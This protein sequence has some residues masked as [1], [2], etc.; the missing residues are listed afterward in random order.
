M[1]PIIGLA[2]VLILAAACTEQSD[3]PQFDPSE[4]EAAARQFQDFAHAFNYSGLREATTPNFEF[5]IFGQ[6]MTL[7]EFETMLRGMEAEL[8]GQ[9]MGTYEIFEF[10]TR[11]VG[12]VAY[13][14]WLSDNWLESSVF[15]HD[16]DRWLVDQ[17][18]A[19]PIKA[20]AD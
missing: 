2:A 10:H 3:D 12:D 17:A 18:F 13:S 14:S 1:K 6:R 11:I 4:I 19:I 15:I 20:A 16:G 9:P 7:D 8:E 5:L